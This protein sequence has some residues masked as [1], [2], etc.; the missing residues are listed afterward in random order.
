MKQTILL[1]ETTH[2]NSCDGRGGRPASTWPRLCDELRILTRSAD[3]AVVMSAY[4][5]LTRAPLRSSMAAG[6]RNPERGQP[7]EQAPGGAS[8]V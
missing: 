2:H 6:D 7:A 1:S 5:P 4:G 8:A 3:T